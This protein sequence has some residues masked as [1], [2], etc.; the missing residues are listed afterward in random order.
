MVKQA[1]VAYPRRIDLIGLKNRRG[2]S[3]YAI[4]FAHYPAADYFGQ[5]YNPNDS[6]TSD[7]YKL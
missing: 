2:V 3:S 4:P 7:D 5:V 1:K 6:D